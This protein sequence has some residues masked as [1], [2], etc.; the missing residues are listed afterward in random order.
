MSSD[1]GEI[2]GKQLP[3][4]STWKRNIIKQKKANGEEHAN[5]KGQNIQARIQGP[6]CLC[7]RK[8]FSKFSG[9]EK[10]HILNSFNEMGDKQRQ[11]T[12]LCG[13]VSGIPK[14]RSRERVLDDTV[15][16]PKNVTYIY[17]L[18]VGS[19]EHVVCRKAFIALHGITG[20]RLQRLQ[21]CIANGNFSPSDGRGKHS[22]HSC[23]PDEV[24]AKIETHI[25]SYPYRVCHYGKQ[26][27]R[28]RYLNGEL[29][30]R[31]MWMEYLR[32]NEPENFLSITAQRDVKC[33]VKYEF[34]LK[35]YKDNFNYSFGKP[36]VDVC[37][38]CER[39]VAKIAAEENDVLNKR[40][41]L[42]LEVHQKKAKEFY[43]QMKI[44]CERAK[45]ETDFEAITMDFM[46]NIPFPQIPV[47]EM[48]YA[49]QLWLYLFGVH[50]TSTNQ[51]YVYP[52]TELEGRKT[53]NEVVSFL[54]HFLST[55]LPVNVKHLH[56]FSDACTS[57][58][59]NNTVVY[60]LAS[61]V[62]SGRFHSIKHFYPTRGHSYLP[63]DR[64]FAVI[65]KRLK[66][67]D[68]VYSSDEWIK[69]IKDVSCNV[70]VIDV[71][72]EMIRDFK[73]M[74]QP[75]FKKT[76]RSVRGKINWSVTKYKVI[77]YKDNT[78]MASTL[79]SALFS[80]TFRLSRSKPLLNKP[81]R[82][83]SEELRIK[84]AKAADIRKYIDS[85][86]PNHS[87]RA[88][89]ERLSACDEN[90]ESGSDTEDWD[91]E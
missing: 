25:R 83:Y 4:P 27:E 82:L 91:S 17:K 12:Y 45:N 35:Y 41:S 68:T 28:K 78:V 72:Q 42:E 9:S 63:C 10:D 53:P 47:T 1:E 70:T 84:P 61:L 23:I 51:A 37:S 60:Y 32:K 11:D 29:T 43:R 50:V 16:K 40:L 69:Q 36:R 33:I 13:L 71:T 66:R 26:N 57:Q 56:I 75:F 86:P 74:L 77:E 90:N 49:R 64:D 46:Q 39:L 5:W 62:E 58:N 6:D 81:A 48:F 30:V 2:S 31:K 52:Y 3:Q 73:S 21:S 20:N 18:R 8:C 22:N 34:F 76:C 55:Y 15:S 79:S 24:L 14:Q 87:A 54:Q 19:N 89:F 80:D 65:S 44:S 85:I 59:R 7:R 38:T 67:A 88:L